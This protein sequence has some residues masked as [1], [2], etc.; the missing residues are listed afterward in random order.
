MDI[1]SKEK[2]SE[3]MSKIRGKNTKPELVVRSLLHS[4]GYRFRLHR[5]DLPGTPDIVLPKYKTVIFVNGCFWHGH[6]GCP[7]Y[8]PP[9]SNV[10]YWEEKIA[11][12]KERDRINTLLLQKLGWKVLEIWECELTDLYTLLSKLRH[13]L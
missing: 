9:K 3:M 8:K 10:Q 5:K 11:K 1:V 2:R 6:K 13:Q 7:I 12:N 4:M